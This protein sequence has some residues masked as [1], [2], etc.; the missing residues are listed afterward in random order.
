LIKP[1]NLTPSLL[2]LLNISPRSPGFVKYY[3]NPSISEK[4]LQIG[5]KPLH[6]L[7]KIPQKFPKY[8]QI[9][10]EPCLLC[11]RPSNHSKNPRNSSEP[12]EKT[13]LHPLSHQLKKHEENYPTHDLKLAVVVYALK[14]WRHYLIGHRCEI[15]SGHK[16]LKYIFSQTD[17]NLR[18]RSWLELI[19]D[20]DVRINDHLGKA[21]VVVDA[22][23]RKK[24]YNATFANRMRPKL[25]Q[26]I[27]YLNL[28]M[29]NETAMIV[30]VEPTLKAEIKKAQ[31]EDEKLR[32]IRQLIME[33]LMVRET[34]M[35]PQSEAYS[36]ANYPGSSRLSIFNSPR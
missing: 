33:N 4:Y 18:Q 19:K 24:Y 35:C 29:V 15:Y 32:E 21:N 9:L 14:I 1:V 10:Q 22:L 7:Q 27:G 26:E 12:P 30:E 5:P 36:R 25:R 6:P 2:N 31:L 23:S 3:R 16:S 11:H 28:T 34:V 17:L 20:Y 8:H 13:I